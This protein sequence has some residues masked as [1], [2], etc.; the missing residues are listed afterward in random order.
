MCALQC[1]TRCAECIGRDDI[2]TRGDVFGVKLPHQCRLRHQRVGGPEWEPDIQPA[3]LQFRSH[4][5]IKNK[6][7]LCIQCIV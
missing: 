1:A 3:H 2:C 5:A 7:R 4:G 6:N